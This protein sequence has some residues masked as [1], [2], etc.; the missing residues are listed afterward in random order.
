MC[1]ATVQVLPVMVLRARPATVSVPGRSVKTRSTVKEPRCGRS[2]PAGEVGDAVVDQVHA[3]DSADLDLVDLEASLE[4]AAIAVLQ[5]DGDSAAQC[6]RPTGHNVGRGQTTASGVRATSPAVASAAA[7]P[8][9]A[10]I[11][12]GH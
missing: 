2:A 6:A 8:A 5:L 4:E 3:P 11:V 7:A 1:A 12:L 10:V 9:V